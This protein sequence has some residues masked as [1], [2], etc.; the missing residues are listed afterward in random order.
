[1]SYYCIIMLVVQYFFIHLCSP[2]SHDLSNGEC[3]APDLCDKDGRHSLVQSCAVHVD[4]GSDGNDKA[5]HS[6]VNLV[7]L[8]KTL[9]GHW[10]GS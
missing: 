7:L 3:E 8:L 9:E 4:G 1:M 2:D 10:Q 6:H 5:S